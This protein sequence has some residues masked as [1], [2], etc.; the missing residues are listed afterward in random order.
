MKVFIRTYIEIFLI[1]LHYIKI[2]F[3]WKISRNLECSSY[4]YH[5]FCS[6]K[7]TWIH[8]F[9]YDQAKNQGWLYLVSPI[10][11]LHYRIFLL[12]FCIYMKRYF[13]LFKKKR[14]QGS[15]WLI[16]ILNM[17]SNLIPILYTIYTRNIMKLSIIKVVS[18]QFLSINFHKSS[19]LSEKYQ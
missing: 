16:R 2:Y 18:W 6:I 17:Y 12:Y 15:K 1:Y 19:I 13:H 11:S 3:V 8:L 5:R 7:M 14:F 10:K 9:K 4:A